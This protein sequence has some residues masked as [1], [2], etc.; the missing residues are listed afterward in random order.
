MR[1]PTLWR[2]H[3][4]PTRPA[5][6]AAPSLGNHTAHDDVA[7]PLFCF[8]SAKLPLQL[9]LHHDADHSPQ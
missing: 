3:A 7:V 1:A 4:Q 6:T 9:A 5:L 2:P 8:F